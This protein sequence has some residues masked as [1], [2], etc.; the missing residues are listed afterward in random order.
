MAQQQW[1][2]YGANGYTGR[3]LVEQAGA[4]GMRPFLAGRD[5][6]TLKAM[7]DQFGVPFRAFELTDVQSVA[8]ALQD[9]DIVVNCAGPFSATAAV[10]AEACIYAGTHYIDITGEI[11]VFE[12]LQT[13]DERAL[14]AKVTLLPGAGFDVVASDCLAAHLHS[15]LPEATQLQLGFCGEGGTSPGTLKTMI[16]MLGKGGRVRRGGK[17]V[18]V[19]AGYRQKG[20]VFSDG[21][22]RH[23]MT[24]PWG[25]ISTAYRSTAIPNIRV[26]TAVPLLTAIAIRVLSPLLIL[27]R[28]PLLKNW[29][30]RVVGTRVS[31][32][33]AQQRAEGCMRLWGEVRDAEGE[34]RVAWLD[35]PEGYQFTAMSCLRVV[36]R[37]L[38]GDVQLGFQT[39]SGAFGAEFVSSLP[40]CQ[41][42]DAESAEALS[43]GQS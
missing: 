6:D 40:D 38:Q 23:C 12:H 34:S 4:E 42:T 11:E 5:R 15:E 29:L 17:I 36:K 19:P 16:E 43:V 20:I 7:S 28:V 21:R 35:V 1:M 14:K 27:L 3:L 8:E 32:P 37:V 9:M 41:F 30:K 25:D 39:P 31:G 26:Y 10:M 18:K 2:I 22:R 24:I 33:N 13:L